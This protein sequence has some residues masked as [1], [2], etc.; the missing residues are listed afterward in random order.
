M[1]KRLRI[2]RSET[3]TKVFLD[4]T[5][6]KDVVSYHLEENALSLAAFLT[7]KIEVKNVACI[8]KERRGEGAYYN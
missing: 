5:E 6:V 8:N 7:M 3:E 2:E 1:A 4:G